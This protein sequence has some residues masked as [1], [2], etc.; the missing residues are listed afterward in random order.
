M[1]KTLE[2]MSLEELLESLPIPPWDVNDPDPWMRK[3]ARLHFNM[4]NEAK[5][6][7]LWIDVPAD[8]LPAGSANSGSIPTSDTTD[9]VTCT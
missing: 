6:E 3:S 1:N 5:K 2:E 4:V 9:G 8:Q 7:N